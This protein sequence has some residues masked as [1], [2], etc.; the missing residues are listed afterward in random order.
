ML[1]VATISYFLSAK[2]LFDQDK[3]VYILDSVASLAETLAAESD[4]SI[5]NIIRQLHTIAI[6][7]IQGQGHEKIFNL[8]FVL[9]QLLETE[10]NILGFSI[11]EYRSGS[12]YRT[13]Y[14][15]LI[16]NDVEDSTAIASQ[17]NNEIQIKDFDTKNTPVF[18]PLLSSRGD[19]LLNISFRIIKDDKREV[20]VKAVI[21][22]SSR[23]ELFQRSKLYLTYIVDSRAIFMIHS[24]VLQIGNTI[25]K[26][27]KAKI[28]AII[29]SRSIKGAYEGIKLTPEGKELGTVIA[30]KKMPHLGLVTIAEIP[31]DVAYQVSQRLQEKSALIGAL[32]LCIGTII[33]VIL[34]RKLT[35]SLDK[36]TFATNRIAE[37]D[38]S[39]PV[40]QG[41]LDEVGVLTRHFNIMQSR[42]VQLL[43][44]TVVKA[45]MEKELETA[46]IVQDSFF[47]R[48]D[49]VVGDYEIS[50]FHK[51]SSECGGD[52]W[53]AFSRDHK[54]FVFVGDATG[55]GVP[56]A[57]MTAVAHS[58]TTTVAQ[59]ARHCPG[60]D[61]SPVAILEILN[62]AVYRAGLGKVKMTLICLEI[63][64][65]S[66]EFRYSN[67]SHESPLILRNIEND[68]SQNIQIDCLS[69]RPSGCLGNG[70]AEIFSMHKERLNPG[71]FL[72]FY[73]DGLI[74]SRN[75]KGQEFGERKLLKSLE[76]SGDLSALELKRRITGRFEDFLEKIPIQDDV[77]LV[78]VKRRWNQGVA[79][80]KSDLEKI[81]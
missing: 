35:N 53:G 29:K 24:D 76:G 2:S 10:K 6:V 44:Q 47:P 31:V 80:K 48:G 67:A 32:I 4:A 27:N 14:E 5:S 1:F 64:F 49:F 26:F 41:S 78:V 52:F 11:V 30:F 75:K 40:P 79:M 68:S 65:Q 19:P 58:C 56:A 28:E 55:H 66:G 45:R 39:I 61:M 71:E 50:G 38:F 12:K 17:L 72:I 20:V 77:T 37:G 54:L 63:D 59:M 46:Q 60:W 81:S 7:V 25:E 15:K 51:A 23:I 69:E 70:D 73:T 34:S 16:K 8:D 42:I 21:D 74:E 18:N 57:L 22:Q 33:S 3:S 9:N 62:I 43:E 36:L 13:I